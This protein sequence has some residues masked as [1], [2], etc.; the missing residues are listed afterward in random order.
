MGHLFLRGI[1]FK[2][3]STFFRQS[4]LV[5]S[6]RGLKLQLGTLSVGE[7]LLHLKSPPQHKLLPSS[8]NPQCPLYFLILHISD[9]SFIEW[10]MEEA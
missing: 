9:P 10:T 8:F 1:K 5:E 7:H 3:K 6:T 2:V 4:K